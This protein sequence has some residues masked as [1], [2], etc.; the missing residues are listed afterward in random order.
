VLKTTFFCAIAVI[1]C[2]SQGCYP[3]AYY[4]PNQ[5][6]MPHLKKQHDA[7]IEASTQTGLGTHDGYEF[8]GTYSPLPHLAVMTNIF[9]VHRTPST[10][11]TDHM[12]LYE[13][14]VG[15]YQPLGT[16]TLSLFAGY[17]GGKV[18]SKYYYDGTYN[19]NVF[20]GSSGGFDS[21]TA[22]SS[23]SMNR[24]FIQ[25]AIT[26]Q[27]KDL[28]VGM[29]WRINRLDFPNGDID[30]KLMLNAPSK[31]DYDALQFIEKSRPLWFSELG[32][33]FLIRIRPCTIGMTGTLLFNTRQ[34]G[35]YFDTFSFGL[36]FGINLAD[37]KPEKK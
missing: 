26:V 4:V 29:A 6:N 28:E 31:S 17:G 32:G 30:A 22:L 15:Y 36:L 10:N 23:L 24:L 5:L 33:R 14:A 12:S 35:K 8:R 9:K 20:T 34:L 27:E 13:G 1:L 21:Y 7:V 25:P 18:L 2:L 3:H 37:L 11:N 19:Y 16:T